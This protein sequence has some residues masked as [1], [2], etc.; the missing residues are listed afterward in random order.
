APAPPARQI[1][2]WIMRPDARLSEGD[3]TGLK[4][5]RTQCPD[6]DTLPHLPPGFTHL[7]RNRGGARLETWINKA[8]SSPFPEIRG[9]AAGLMRDY[10]AGVAR[11]PPHPH[12][13]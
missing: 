10:H 9:F 7:V 4:L 8:N 1:T 2:A 12:S 13:A 6:L 5:A 11:L 3:R